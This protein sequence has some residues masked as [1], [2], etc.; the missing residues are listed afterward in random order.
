MI[1]GTLSVVKWLKNQLTRLATQLTMGC[2]RFRESS[3]P[4]KSIMATIQWRAEINTLPP[5]GLSLREVINEH[6]N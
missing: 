6:G 3:L 4:V 2:V 1:P 5:N